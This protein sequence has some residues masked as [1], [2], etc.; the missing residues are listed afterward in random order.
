MERHAVYAVTT[1]GVTFRVGAPVDWDVA[2][3]RWARLASRRRAGRKPRVRHMRRWY[4]VKAF[5]VRSVDRH[6]IG[7]G[8]DRHGRAIHAPYRACRVTV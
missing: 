8:S 2:Q 6:G 7:L 5:E 4:P 3:N 1:S